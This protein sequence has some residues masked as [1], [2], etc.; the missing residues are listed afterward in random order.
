M[1]NTKLKRAQ[2]E[3]EELERERKKKRKHMDEGSLEEEEPLPD[4][5]PP[6]ALTVCNISQESMK[7]F[8]VSEGRA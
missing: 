4:V 5:L 3:R 6:A 8:K 7:D 1:F 2:A